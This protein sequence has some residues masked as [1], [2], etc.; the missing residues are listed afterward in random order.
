ML[1]K[2]DA[3]DSYD[4]AGVGA[5]AKLSMAIA[6]SFVASRRHVT[7]LSQDKAMDNRRSLRQATRLHQRNL[8]STTG[9]YGSDHRHRPGDLAESR[10]Q[11]IGDQG[12]ENR[13]ISRC[14]N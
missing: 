1:G 14:E 3:E 11:L 12:R 13:L 9:F 6:N 5:L 8:S 2:W 4:N 10:D 7:G